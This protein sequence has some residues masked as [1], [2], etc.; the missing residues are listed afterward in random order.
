MMWAL[1]YASAYRHVRLPWQ[2][3]AHSYLECNNRLTDLEKSAK[4]ARRPPPPTRQAMSEEKKR[5]IP[6]G[7][8]VA[9]EFRLKITRSGRRQEKPP[10][11]NVEESRDP[12][13]P[14]YGDEE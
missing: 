10:V 3:E 5:V 6:L 2:W 14:P 13:E 11:Y 9:P 12:E 1:R 4:L 7:S 8:P